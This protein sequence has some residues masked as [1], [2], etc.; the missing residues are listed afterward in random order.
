MEDVAK[1][2]GYLDDLPEFRSAENFGYIPRDKVVAVLTG[3]QG[4]PRAALARIASDEHPD[5]ALTAGD[6]V[7]FSSRAIPGNER[8]SAPSSTA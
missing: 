8:L 2:C 1:E 4:E 5:I 7:I 3:S 6:R